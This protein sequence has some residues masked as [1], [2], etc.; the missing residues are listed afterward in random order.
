VGIESSIIISQNIRILVSDNFTI[1]YNASLVPEKYND[2]VPMY[3]GEQIGWSI[4]D[5]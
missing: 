5:V 4:K 1:T 2:V 3:A